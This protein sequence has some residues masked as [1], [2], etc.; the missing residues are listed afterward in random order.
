MC[1]LISNT[2]SK[3]CG[4]LIVSIL[5]MGRNRLCLCCLY[6]IKCLIHRHIARIALRRTGYIQCSLRKYYSCLW[7]AYTLNCLCC[8]HCYNK[9]VRICISNILTS[10]YHYSS[11]YKLN[12]FTRI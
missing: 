7:H 12:I 10:T 2:M 9:C 11:C 1:I 3:L 4:A 6:Y 8:T 5:K